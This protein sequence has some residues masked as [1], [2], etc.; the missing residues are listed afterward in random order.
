RLFSSSPSNT[1]GAN[2][3]L[4]QLAITDLTRRAPSPCRCCDPDAVGPEASD[5]DTTCPHDRLIE[6]G[7]QTSPPRERPSLTRLW[8]R[9]PRGGVGVEWPRALAHSP[10]EYL[11][12]SLGLPGGVLSLSLPELYRSRFT[13]VNQRRAGGRTGVLRKLM[14]M[15]PLVPRMIR[16]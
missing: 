16:I 12:P 6:V 4:I 11:F 1:G 3:R 10:P 8:V 9:E 2:R 13:S 5:K 14:A 15:K 7:S